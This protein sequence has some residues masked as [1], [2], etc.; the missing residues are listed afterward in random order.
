[1][2]DKNFSQ[3]PMHQKIKEPEMVFAGKHITNHPLKGLCEY[4]PYSLDLKY[5][6]S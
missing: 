3:L 6:S 5:L 4:G 1:M 2:S